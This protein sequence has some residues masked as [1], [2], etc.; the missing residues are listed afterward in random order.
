MGATRRSTTALAIGGKYLGTARDIS[1]PY[2]RRNHLVDCERDDLVKL[3][4]SPK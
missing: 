4:Q 1:T 3:R 2:T